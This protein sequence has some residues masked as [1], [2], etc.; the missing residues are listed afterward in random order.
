MPEG[1]YFDASVSGTSIAI[2][3]ISESGHIGSGREDGRSAGFRSSQVGHG[4]NYGIHMREL[5]QQNGALGRRIAQPATASMR[6]MISPWA[7]LT[8]R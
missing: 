7:V 5:R 1:R 2:K 3:R 8:A 4:M 6:E